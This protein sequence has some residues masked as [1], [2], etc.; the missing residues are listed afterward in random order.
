[1]AATADE[2]LLAIGRYVALAFE[3]AGM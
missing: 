3:L 2:V 1:M